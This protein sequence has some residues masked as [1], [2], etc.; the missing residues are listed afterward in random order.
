MKRIVFLLLCLAGFAV[1]AQTVTREK[2]HGS[3]KMA[4][5]RYDEITID[6]EKREVIIPEGAKMPG[7]ATH[8]EM[9]KNLQGVVSFYAG[10]ALTFTADRMI[11]K[12]P[13]EVADTEYLLVALDGKTYLIDGPS[14]EPELIITMTDEEM[15]LSV[16]PQEDMDF[17][18]NA[19]VFKKIEE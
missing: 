15:L 8:E 9:K 17:Q 4:A 12:L 3:W 1:S 16:T 5:I 10:T 2:L 13:G 11:W 18:Q 14:S 6:L 19:M 7:T